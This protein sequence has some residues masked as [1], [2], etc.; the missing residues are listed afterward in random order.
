MRHVAVIL[1]TTLAALALPGPAPA[2]DGAAAALAAP[3]ASGEPREGVPTVDLARYR[4]DVLVLEFM[5]TWCGP[6][7]SA[8][9]TV[10]GWHERYARGLRIV[11]VSKEDADLLER[12][13]SEAGIASE[14]EQ[15]AD[16]ALAERFGIRA[17]PTFIIFD[18][19]LG[20]VGRVVGAG[21]E[22]ARVEATFKRL[23]DDGAPSDPGSPSFAGA[24]AGRAVGR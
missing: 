18:R 4:G 24:P 21:P 17:V 11:S 7:K 1:L 12:F 15:D 22:L 5:A 16:G 14:L 13:K 19:E 2:E 20:E 9:P 23:L 3:A 10:N 8:I 6:C